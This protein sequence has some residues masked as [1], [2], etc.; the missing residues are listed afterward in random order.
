MNSNLN[1]AV[2]AKIL[3]LIPENIKPVNFFMDILDLGK[4]S[5]YRRLR[6]DKSLSFEEI[7]KLSAE[8]GFSLDELIDNNTNCFLFNYVGS[9][10]Q[11]P[12]KNLLDFLYYYEDF[13]TR[14]AKAENS[15]IICTMNHILNTMLVGNESL[16]KFVYYRWMHQIKEVPLDYFY[17]D[18][19]IPEETKELCARITLLSQKLKKVSFIFD[20][21]IYLNMLK[22]I[23]YFYRR[24]LIN[25]EELEL[26]KKEYLNY[27]SYM[28]DIIKK[29]MDSYGTK[30][31]F[32]LSVFK[33]NST[34]SYVVWDD[35][36]ESSF[37]H[38]YGYPIFTRNKK[39]TGRHK[40]WIDSL[41]KYSTLIS[42]SNEFLQAEFIN[43]QRS[44]VNILSEHSIDL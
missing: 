6:G 36:E 9:Y 11:N 2:L 20:D 38:Y 14:S 15:E 31:E 33:I 13:L 39:V 8:L 4:E 7:Y 21:D 37:W 23:Q 10:E 42:R 29:G 22:E 18:L 34:T 25:K 40:F 17:S 44:Y 5:A 41:K 1:E 12:E 28:G 26:L 43:K 19:M 32:Y 3:N 24:N 30:F 16:F 35:N 27:I